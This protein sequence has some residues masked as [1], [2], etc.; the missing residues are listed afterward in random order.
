MNLV[1]WA[2]GKNLLAPELEKHFNLDKNCFYVEPF[3]GGG[4]SFLNL[5][6]QFAAGSDK[7][8]SL[9]YLWEFV[10]DDLDSITDGY[11]YYHE[12]HS[13][14]GYE[15]ARKLYNDLYKDIE[16]G[17]MLDEL[18]KDIAILFLYLLNTG[19]NGLC[20]Y[21][22]KTGFNVPIGDKLPAVQSVREKLLIV[23]DR[24][25]NTVF[26]CWD[27][28]KTIKHYQSKS[29]AFFYC[30][31]PYSQVNGKGFQDYTGDWKETDADR[32]AQVLNVSGCDFAVSE[33]DLP[34]V[35]ER[36]AGY[37][38]IELQ[39]NRSIGGNRS[40]VNEVLIL[41]RI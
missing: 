41:S 27:F 14:D 1:K 35:R 33:I 36:Y 10:R 2:G 34:A 16:K 30:D 5:K 40:K 31:P 15:N 8:Q 25:K 3:L 18:K 9:I 23:Q 32:L 19:Y 28:E 17:K 24:I 11:A 37:P 26:H 6:K 21:S 39:A 20:R 12:L 38:I 29:N 4:G 7:N 22:L 13:P